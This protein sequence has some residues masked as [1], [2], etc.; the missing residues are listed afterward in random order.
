MDLFKAENFI[1]ATGIEDTFIPQVRP[2]LRNLD[3]YALMQHYEQWK[4]DFDLIADTGVQALR[5]GI[6]WYRVQPAP[7]Q[8]DW[9]WV[10]AALDYLVNVKGIT[11][12]IDLMH[13]GTP[14][15]LD[16]S[17]INHSY[18]QR[19]AEYAYAVAER[20]HSIIRYYTPMNEPMINAGGS[21]YD[22]YWPPYLTGYDGYARLILALSKGIICTL[23]ALKA[24]QPDAVT[25]Q[26]ESIWKL[27]TSHEEIRPKVE[28]H[29]TRKYLAFDLTT[30]RVDENH[31]LFSWLRE[32]GAT[33]ADFVW[34]QD[35]AI[36]YDIFGANFYP[37]SYGPARVRKHTGGIYRHP[38]RTQGSV[39]GDL[40]AEVYDR[41]HMPIMITETSSLGTVGTRADWMDS[42]IQTVH[43]LRLR[44]IPVVGYT[45]FPFFSMIS[46]N[47]R[48]GRKPLAHY[49]INLGIYDVVLDNDGK[50]RRI[51]TSLVDR[52]NDHISQPMPLV[53]QA[54][55][56]DE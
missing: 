45:W 10:D 43:D 31:L 7:N 13:Y 42:T 39:I 36:K 44:G 22:G 17:F 33:D 37:W 49:L 50:M 40:L 35:N 30:G 14:L 9:H 38:V 55:T 5:W 41:Y 21:G 48:Y 1:W 46:W 20:Y 32:Y 11:P 23:Q 54:R 29:N 3:E 8:W 15:W 28:M 53:E 51:P 4:S 52:F 19:V 26:V 18:P 27:Y 56:F 25:I 6:P 12:L 24:A 34:F 2:G 47:Y 16:N